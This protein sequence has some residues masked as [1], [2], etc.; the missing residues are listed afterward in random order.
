M[1]RKT[2]LRPG[3]EPC[4][5]REATAV[6]AAESATLSD[7]N[8]PV[9]QALSCEGFDSIF[10]GVEITGGSS[11]TMTIEALFRDAEAVDG[12]RWKRVLL[13]AKEGIT[14]IATPVAEDT[15]ALDGT[16]FVELRVFGAKQVMLRVKA[17]A[18]S[19]STTAWKI[20]AAAGRTRSMSGQNRTT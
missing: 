9:A 19:G 14:P 10:V 8:Y 16:A 15:G 6:I 12:A 2:N 11:P 3:F 4:V 13:G 20:L 18:N 7:A 17:V 5:V 1:A